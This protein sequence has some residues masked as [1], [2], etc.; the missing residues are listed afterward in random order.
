MADALDLGSSAVRR[1]GSSPLLRT[2]MGVVIGSEHRITTPAILS[3]L[4]HRGI[5][6]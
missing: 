4:F 5:T 2:N 3:G 6:W 1:R